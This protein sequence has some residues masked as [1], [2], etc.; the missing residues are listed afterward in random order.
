MLEKLLKL[1]QKARS[2]RSLEPLIR[3]CHQL[4]S[5][6][7][8]ANVYALAKEVIEGYQALPAQRREAFFAAL[9][10]GFSPN[11]E[12]VL[13]T[14]RLYAQAPTAGHL[15]Q[16][17]QVVEPP[18]QEL[19]RRVNR[20]PGGT[21]V[22]LAM[23][24]DLLD[25]RKSN[26][27][28]AVV[29]ADFLH[30]L[31]SWFNPGFL[32]LE[33]VDWESSASLL[34]KLIQHEAVH[35]ITGWNDLRRRLQPDRRCYAFF[36]PQLPGEPLIFVEVALEQDLPDAIAPLLEPAPDT[37]VSSAA[38]TAVFY[39]I[40]NCQPG[41]RGVSLGNFLIKKVADQLKTELPQLKVFCTLSPIPGFSR[42]LTQA[43]AED[44][45]PEWAGAL[46]R[47]KDWRQNHSSA[48][49]SDFEDMPKALRDDLTGLCARFLVNGSHE[50]LSDPVAR[51]HLDNGARLE[52]IN[53]AADLSRKAVKQSM[54]LMVN[55]LYDIDAVETRHQQFVDNKVS[56]SAAVKRL[57]K[58]KP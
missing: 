29:D 56:H 18:R 6:R 16:L 17:T 51:F 13:T 58:P 36:H 31:S 57:L 24:N 27:E 3:S 48:Q 5:E 33:R 20:A 32:R 49:G 37:P 34:E 50:G 42:W 14:A 8:Q 9:A 19:L 40:S 54:G 35:E 7:G 28:L 41:L 53:F 12:Q 55:Y 10:T 4:I 26:P 11:P 44:N 38:R 43:M 39:S 21:A 23:R 52:R 30:L 15:A 46:Q 1:T 25:L 2:D 47:V 45:K 22:L